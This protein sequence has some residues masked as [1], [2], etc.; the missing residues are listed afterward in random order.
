M[1]SFRRHSLHFRRTVWLA[2]WTLMLPILVSLVHHPAAARTM[3]APMPHCSMPNMAP[4]PHDGHGKSSSEKLP[5]CPVCQGLHFFNSG[6]IPPTVVSFLLV[7]SAAIVE[8]PVSDH[9]GVG[10]CVATAAW[11]RAPPFFA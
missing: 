11:P 1:F 8:L 3:G 9:V 10:R 5:I 7:R 6:F 4:V 2:V